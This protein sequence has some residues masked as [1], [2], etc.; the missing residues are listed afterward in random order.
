MPRYARPHTPGALIHVISRFV[1]YEYRLA[2]PAE[3]ALFLD[4]LAASLAGTDWR[5]SFITS[6]IC[7]S[8]RYWENLP[9]RRGAAFSWAG[10]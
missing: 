5:A 2:G 3:R 9:R 7:G 1:N 6:A 8:G 10:G 4:C